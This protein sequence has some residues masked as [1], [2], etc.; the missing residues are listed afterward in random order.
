MENLIET[1]LCDL[2]ICSKDSIKPFYPKVRDRDDVAVNQC[3]KSGVVFLSRCD[4]MDISHY[5]NRES[6][7]YWGA[8]D[9]EAAVMAG[10]EDTER[11]FNQFANIIAGKKWVDV[12]TGAG[13]ILDFLAPLAAKTCAVEPQIEA[14]T[15]LE[16]SGYTVYPSVSAI[17]GDDFDVGTLFHVFEHLTHPV[18]TL[19]ELHKK[20]APG[21]KVIIEVP[22]ARDFLLSF[23]DLEAFKKF[24]F[25]SEHLILHT[26]ESLIKFLQASG[27]QK[28]SVT[29][30]QRYPLANH[31]HW[32]AEER[33][34]GHAVWDFL[35]TAALDTAYGEML[36]GLDKTDT[37]IA[38]AIK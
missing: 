36:A 23:L 30:F 7:D 26:R 1:L 29:G 2:G 15:W 20:M 28:V 31:L 33:P 19:S 11:R 9:R 37:L 16:K 32:L 35:R 13:G 21:G 14:K 4:H 17:E 8:D 27:F 10:F 24:T 22:H 5:E 12:G 3:E 18:K 25:W 6:F 38:A 34:G